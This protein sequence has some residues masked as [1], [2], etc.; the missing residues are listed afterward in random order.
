M[1]CVRWGISCIAP[2]H[3]GYTIRYVLANVEFMKEEKVRVVML[4]PDWF[5]DVSVEQ[6]E[7]NELFDNVVVEGVDCEQA[8]DDGVSEA[9][10]LLTHY[11]DVSAAAMD[12]TGCS[13]VSRYATGIDGIDVEAATERDVRVTRVPS[14][15]DREVAEHIVTLALAVLRGLPRYT[16]ATEAG[17]WEW[18]D[19]TPLRQFQTITFGFVAFGRKAKAAAELAASLGF[20]VCAYDPYLSDNEITDNG[21]TPVSFDELLECADIISINSP[22]T[23]E[24][25][26]MFDD[27]VFS[28]MK[29]NSILLNTA[30]GKI[31][32]EGDLVEALENGPLF[33][34]GLDVLAVEPPK[35]NNSLLKRDDVFVTPHAAWYSETSADTLRRRGTAIAAAAYRR[36]HHPGIVNDTVLGSPD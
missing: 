28:R 19:A 27:S 25:E 7:F 35:K 9:D 26:K 21:V 31:V 10:I 36:K 16:A 6:S 32:D 33:G 23:D 12:K 14:Y 30:R 29:K 1:N 34:A 11:T 5:G 18:Q 15:C 20:N 22:L 4:D 24:T 3:G 17:N 8:T 2:P 13:V